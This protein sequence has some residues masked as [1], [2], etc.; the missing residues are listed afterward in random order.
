MNFAVTCGPPH[1]D[2]QH[3]R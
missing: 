2:G 1:R 3:N